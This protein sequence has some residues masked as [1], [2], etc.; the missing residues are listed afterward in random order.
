MTETPQRPRR[1]VAPPR[2]ERL[3]TAVLDN[4]L[5]TRPHKPCL[6]WD[7][8]ET[9]FHV[10]VNRGP[11]HRKQATVTF[12]VVYYLKDQ[13]G[14]PHSMRLGRYLDEKPHI[15]I[16]LNEEGHEQEVSYSC[17]NPE[18]M[19]KV[20]RKIR[21]QAKG[22][23]DLR[24]LRVTG[25]NFDD[26]IKRYLNRPQPQVQRTL[27][28]TQRIFNTYVLPEWGT[29][30]VESIDK[31]HVAELLNKIAAG[32]IK[33]PDTGQMIGTFAVARATRVQL[34]AFYNWYVEELGSKRFRSPIVKSKRWPQ[35]Q[36][37]ERVLKGDEIRALWR[38]TA[39]MGIYGAVVRTALLTGQRFRKVG[40]MQ[41]ADFRE[42]VKVEA[43]EVDGVFV[44]EV[45]IYDVWD[46]RKKDDP[47]NKSVSPVPLSPLAREVINSVPKVDGDNPPGF[48]F[49][50][51]GKR[52]ITDLSKGKDTLDKL[53]LREL[54][55]LAVERGEAPE[56]VQLEPWQHRDLRRTA[57][58]L[59]SRAGV[60]NDIA[61]L[62]LAHKLGTVRHIY[63]RHDYL[64]EKQIAFKRLADHVDMIVK[65]PGWWAK[66]LPLA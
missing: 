24:K 63:D 25:R 35:G 52:P 7:N 12:R 56:R 1:E 48:V 50:V 39:E 36:G 37:R 34:G 15:R 62:C 8:K 60:N 57:R 53:M 29:K 54:R 43:G 26:L 66:Q 49:T 3:T 13:P 11:K 58:T 19:R 22:G 2:R 30:N 64:R 61:E 45:V 28:E 47:V 10:L 33:H 5:R 44:P 14:R 6:I 16:E 65:P 46:A 59:M 9:G 21:D 41:K 20:A 4:L 18:D 55:Q 40:H 27:N 38:A 17:C 42:R 23:T 32:E 31:E 51:T